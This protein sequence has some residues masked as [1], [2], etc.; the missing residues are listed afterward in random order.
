MH[1]K[2]FFFY[3]SQFQFLTRISLKFFYYYFF[4]IENSNRLMCV[5]INRLI[6]CNLSRYNTFYRNWIIYTTMCVEYYYIDAF[7][8]RFSTKFSKNLVIWKKI[9]ER[10]SKISSVSSSNL[11]TIL[12]RIRTSF[13][14]NRFD[15][16]GNDFFLEYHKAKKK[17]S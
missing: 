3:F 11:E 6:S 1:T 16:L 4:L 17:K 12:K 7:L 10:I 14:E 8:K 9:F 2:F 15:S 5:C 13:M